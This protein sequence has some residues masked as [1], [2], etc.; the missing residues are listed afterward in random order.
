MTN[1]VL[2]LNKFEPK[3]IFILDD[4]DEFYHPYYSYGVSPENM[5]QTMFNRPNLKIVNRIDEQQKE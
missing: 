1:E 3:E 5:Y 2:L 4:Y